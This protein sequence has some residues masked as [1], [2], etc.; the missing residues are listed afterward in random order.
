MDAFGTAHRKHASTAVIDEFF[1]KD[2]KMLGYLME[3]E[4]HAVDNVLKDIKRPFVAYY[5]RF[6]GFR[7]RLASSRTY[8]ARLTSSS[9]AVV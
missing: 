8:L 7:L 2:N 4:V 5:G 9:F 6:K 1:S 3:K